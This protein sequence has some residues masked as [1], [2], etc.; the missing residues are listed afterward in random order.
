MRK[1]T[2]PVQEDAGFGRGFT[3][4]E[5]VLAIAL[6]AVLL[7]VVYWTYFNINRSIDAA[8]ENQEAMETGRMLSELIKRDIRCI[9]PNRFSLKAKNEAVEGWSLGQIE[10]VTTAG[11]YSDP[12]KLRRIGYELVVDN[13]GDKIFVRRESKDLSDPFDP[14]NPLDQTAT[15]FELSRIVKGFQ[16]EFYDGTN[17]TQA[18]DSD[19]AGTFPQQF[20]VTFDISDTKGNDKKFV[21]EESI[22]STIQ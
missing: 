12:L 1:W 8:K 14:V 16:L 17:W 11:F 22:Q 18:W 19:T 3:L 6:S 5:V 2:D 9:T 15:V 21:A 20:R 10:F 13:K 4:I 7:T